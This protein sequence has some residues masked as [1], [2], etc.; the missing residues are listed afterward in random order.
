MV[1]NEEEETERIVSLNG[2]SWLRF[3]PSRFKPSIVVDKFSG[4][5]EGKLPK[6]SGDGTYG[7]TLGGTNPLRECVA[8]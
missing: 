2:L 1:D 8:L 3:N 4:V 6:L 5:D 7:T